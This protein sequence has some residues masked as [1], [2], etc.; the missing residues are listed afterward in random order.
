MSNIVPTPPFV[1]LYV[2]LVVVSAVNAFERFPD[3][4]CTA[5]DSE[6]SASTSRACADGLRPCP[7]GRPADPGRSADDVTADL[8]REG[9]LR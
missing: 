2:P 1:A 3:A 5:D 7:P 8:M 9:F 6:A 4:R